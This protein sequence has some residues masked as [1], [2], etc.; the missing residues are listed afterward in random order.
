MNVIC[1]NTM[2]ISAALGSSS[3]SSSLRWNAPKRTDY[4]Y[5]NFNQKPQNSRARRRGQCSIVHSKQFPRVFPER[6]DEMKCKSV[7][8]HIDI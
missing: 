5:P 2:W 8:H 7:M 3:L 4:F 1:L 6:P